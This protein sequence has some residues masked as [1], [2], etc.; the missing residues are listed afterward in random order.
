MIDLIFNDIQPSF[1]L[2]FDDTREPFELE[3]EGSGGSI[4]LDHDK[5]KGRNLPDQ[6]PVASITGLT[7]ELNSA[8]GSPFTNMELE[9]LLK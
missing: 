3:F 4:S 5:L 2:E 7:D 9:A 6:H 8:A 1:E